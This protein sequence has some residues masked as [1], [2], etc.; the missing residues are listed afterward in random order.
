MATN[1]TF[2]TLQ[3]DVQNYLE[4]GGSATTDPTMNAQIPRMINAAERKIAQFLK[5]EGVIEV[6]KDSTGLGSGVSTV[7]KPDRWRQTVSMTYFIGGDA[8]VA[9]PLFPRSLEYCQNY[10]PDSTVTDATQLPRFYA[11]YSLTYWLIVPTPP[12]TYPLQG[13]FYMQPQL[14]DSGN[15]TNFFTNFTPNML[16]YGSLLESAPF[17]KDDERLVTWQ[18][19][20]D[21]EAASLSG[22][23]IQRIL[24]RTALRTAA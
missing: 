7:T 23:D 18:S 21:R 17:L 9:V 4:R 8:N 5:L 13:I 10:W 24:D 11:E 1:V 20:W 6:L 3:S 2:T 19:L 16:L 22:Q 14:L 12:A 15:Q